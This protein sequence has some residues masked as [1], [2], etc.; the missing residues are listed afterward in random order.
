MLQISA[1][2]HKS[3][4][5]VW[6]KRRIMTKNNEKDHMTKAQRNEVYKAYESEF[7]FTTFN[8]KAKFMPVTEKIPD[9]YLKDIPEN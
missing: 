6:G 3:M 4:K 1:T 5:A 7:G 2:T 8:S 9:D